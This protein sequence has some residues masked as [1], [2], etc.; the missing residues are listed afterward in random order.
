MF[1]KYNENSEIDK[2]LNLVNKYDVRNMEK[3]DP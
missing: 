3:V 2:N 1:I